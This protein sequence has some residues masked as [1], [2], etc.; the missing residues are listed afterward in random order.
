MADC[1]KKGRNT[2]PTMDAELVIEIRHLA[3]DGANRTRLA[4]RYGICRRYLYK[5]VRREVWAHV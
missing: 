3:E 1:V 5:I 2:R 4:A